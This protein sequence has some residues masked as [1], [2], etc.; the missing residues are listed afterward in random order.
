MASRARQRA[1]AG[2]GGSTPPEVLV[3]LHGVMARLRAVDEAAGEL[4]RRGTIGL[5]A[6]AGGS[7]AALTGTAAALEPGDWVLPGPRQSAIALARGVSL[8]AWFAQLLGRAA[9]PSRG[10]QAPDHGAWKTA[11][12]VSASTPSGSQLVHAVGVARAMRRAARGEVAV[13]VAGAAACATADFHVAVN[14]AGLWQV[15]VVLLFAR[16][17]GLASQTAT[18]TIAEKA[19]AYGVPGV[20]VDGGDADAVRRAVHEA[21]QRAREGGGPTLIDAACPDPALPVRQEGRGLRLVEGDGA[22]ATDPLARL[23]GILSGLGL[24]DAASEAHER[25][26]AAVTEAVAWAS[27]Q[28]AVPWSTLFADVFSRRTPA[29]EAQRAEALVR[30]S[31]QET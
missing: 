10:R 15:P 24:G 22:E 29:L 28:P 6:P 16:G 13:G 8:R 5:H 2:L 19:D 7:E 17:E 11:R 3:A 1:T 4:S 23:E 21:A 27:D 12:V 30:R 14:F 31:R 9:D 18:A 25:E 20:V 26:I